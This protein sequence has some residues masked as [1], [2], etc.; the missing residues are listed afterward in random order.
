MSSVNAGTTTLAGTISAT[1]DPSGNIST[2]TGDGTQFT[3]DILPGDYLLVD[4]KWLEPTVVSD[5]QL[6]VIALDSAGFSDIA[7]TVI[8]WMKVPHDSEF[9]TAFQFMRGVPDSNSLI[10]PEQFKQLQDV[11]SDLQNA[12]QIY[13]VGTF[14]TS[15]STEFV[16]VATQVIDA[17]EGIH[18]DTQDIQK[19]IVPLE[20]GDMDPGALYKWS[21]ITQLQG[22]VDTIAGDVYV[23]GSG[24]NGWK[25]VN[26]G[27]VTFSDDW[28]S[29]HW[30]TD[31]T[32]PDGHQLPL[33][34]YSPVAS[35]SLT[36]LA[37]KIGPILGNGLWLL[38]GGGTH[39]SSGK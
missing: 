32:T 9:G 35:E 20:S 36:E 21:Y 6:S 3:Q 10:F 24:P 28:G 38:A 22:L 30:T 25:V 29:N 1:A 5:T 31:W 19:L 33:G 14:D 12:P 27:M 11:L 13:D 15:S 18:G 37:G 23:R 26:G 8:N 7:P 2:I 16:S 34:P 4:G 17:Y 39:S